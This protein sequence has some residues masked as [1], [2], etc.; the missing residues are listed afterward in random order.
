MKA[1]E[2]AKKALSF[3]HKCKKN[4]SDPSAS[5]EEVNEQSYCTTHEHEDTK[6]KQQFVFI[7]HEYTYSP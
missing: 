7:C 3:S 1:E 4:S 5:I 6:T 2:R